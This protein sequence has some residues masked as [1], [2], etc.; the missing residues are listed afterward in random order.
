M[1]GYYRLKREVHFFSYIPTMFHTK[2]LGN[3]NHPKQIKLDD[4]IVVTR[5][6]K[7]KQRAIFLK[8]L[9]ILKKLKTKHLQEKL[10]FFLTETT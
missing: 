2:N 10:K 5:S 6:Q 7:E 4:M 1:K 9:I 3:V 8:Y